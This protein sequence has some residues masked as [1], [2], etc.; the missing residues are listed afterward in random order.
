MRFFFSMIFMIVQCC[1][2]HSAES[3]FPYLSGYT[4]LFFCDWRVTNDD[5]GSSGEKCDPDQIRLGDTIFVD[6]AC[7]EEFA[8]DYL[9]RIKEKV[10][11]ITA[12]YG[13]AADE[14]I[15]GP[16]GYIVDD[17]KI[18][19][20]FVQNLDREGSE[21]LIPIPIGL[22][23]KHW[24]HGN[25]ALLDQ[26]IPRA[27]YKTDRNNFV[28]LNFTFWPER[29]DCI[30]HFQKMGA[31]FCWGRSY[32]EFLRD[33]SETMFVISPRGHGLDVHRTWEALLMGSIPV[34]Q[35]ST[36]D[37]LYEDLPVVIVKEWSEA[38][39]EF[40]QER[41]KELRA[42]TWSREKLYA[43]YWFEKVGKIQK[44]LREEAA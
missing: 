29:A 31:Q 37:P 12:N 17:E 10:I 22:A 11:L 40:L 34:V 42:K 35:S 18:A 27:A 5:Y 24:P 26:W 28:Y 39:A 14:Q 1:Q 36:L 32:D 41:Y 23:N 9:P 13:Y 4:W 33:L 43:P 38:T 21:K 3:S 8:R 30:E 25:I 2:L 15:P 16:F 20:W 7:M 44:K 6:F 19:A